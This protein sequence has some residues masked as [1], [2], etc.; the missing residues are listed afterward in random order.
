MLGLYTTFKSVYQRFGANPDNPQDHSAKESRGYINSDNS[1]VYKQNFQLG[2]KPFEVYIPITA[3]EHIQKTFEEICPQIQ[4]NVLSENPIAYDVVLIVRNRIKVRDNSAEVF[5]T[6]NGVTRKMHFVY[7]TSTA[8]QFKSVIEQKAQ[9]TK[10]EFVYDFD[11]LE[12]KMPFTFEYILAL[13]TNNDGY[14]N[15]FLALYTSLSF[16]VY[17]SKIDNGLIRPLY[18]Y[19]EKCLKKERETII[20]QL[21][22][23]LPE[24]NQIIAPPSN[25]LNF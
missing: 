17:N 14:I 3:E 4:V 20:E 24:K 10:D 18:P 5:S 9:Q 6:D 1:V 2:K 16:H 11:K 19:D 21:N 8:K 12:N 7:D 15:E 22:R 23:R 13:D 25:S